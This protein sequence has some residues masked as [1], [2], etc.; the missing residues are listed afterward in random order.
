MSHFTTLK[1]RIVSREHLLEALH[2]L[3]M[4]FETGEL[5]IRGYQGIKTEVEVKVKTQN[6][7]YNIGFRK[8]GDA[9]E[10]V[11]D[12]YGIKDI[13]PDEFLAKIA[14]RYA[15]RASMRK[16]LEQNFEIVSEEILSDNSIHITV[17]RMV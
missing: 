16:L 12:W 8:R 3:H 14:Q 11:A 7:D 5:E 1:T 15:Y 17:R 4:E 13:T 10:M 6:S 9:F 2:D